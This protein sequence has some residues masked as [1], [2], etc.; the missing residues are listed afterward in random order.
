M[1]EVVYQKIGEIFISLSQQGILF[2]FLKNLISLQKV[3]SF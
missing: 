2:V 3:L 1:A